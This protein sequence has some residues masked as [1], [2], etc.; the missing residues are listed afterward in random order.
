MARSVRS[1]QREANQRS[2]RFFV[3]SNEGITLHSRDIAGARRLDHI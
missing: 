3:C 2:K 1:R